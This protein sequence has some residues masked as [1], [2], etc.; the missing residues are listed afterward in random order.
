LDHSFEGKTVESREM[1]RE[2]I[3]APAARSAR[4]ET[5][6]GQSCFSEAKRK[7]IEEAAVMAR[8]LRGEGVPLCFERE[9]KKKEPKSKGKEVWKGDRAGL[10]RDGNTKTSGLLETQIGLVSF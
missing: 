9:W 3:G 1:A 5:K 8:A 10:R 2:T 7:K 4:G 6:K